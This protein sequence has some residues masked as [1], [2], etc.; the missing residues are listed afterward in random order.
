MLRYMSR[1]AQKRLCFLSGLQVYVQAQRRRMLQH[2]REAV[3]R[4][5]RRVG[6]LMPNGGKLVADV[7]LA[8]VCDRYAAQLG[9]D[10]KVKRG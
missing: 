1:L 8:K 4:L 9:Q 7:A 3:H 6:F 2:N 10:V 5:A